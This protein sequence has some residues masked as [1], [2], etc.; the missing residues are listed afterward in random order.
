MKIK[1]FLALLFTVVF[2]VTGCAQQN[3][4]TE[5]QE[6]SEITSHDTNENSETQ[7]PE[8]QESETTET[9][10]SNILITYFT[11]ADNTVV[12][13][14]EAALESAL[15]HYES[16]GDSV[17]DDVDAISS[18]S[19]LPPGNVARMAEWISEETG[20]NLFSIRVTDLYS[21]DYDEC[22]DRASDE[23]AE[24]ARPELSKHVENIDDYDTVF[25][26]YPNWWYSVPMPVLSFID[27][28]NLSGKKI[29]LFCSHGTGGLAR[30]VQDITAEL[31]SDC[32]IEEDVIGI[33]RNDILDGQPEIQEWLNRIGY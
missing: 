23:K 5:H 31:P 11:W 6:Q 25:I 27:E 15:S 7:E 21:S 12:N 2:T 32:E 14:Q 3:Q 26:G 22:M 16:V 13:D 29:V 20:G 1:T 9:G 24:N 18:A 28:H 17:G 33:Y 10:D 4:D 30:S 19:I 8:T